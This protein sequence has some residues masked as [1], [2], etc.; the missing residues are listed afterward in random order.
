[1]T[2]FIITLLVISQILSFYLIFSRLKPKVIKPDGLVLKPIPKGVSYE[3]LDPNHDLIY[4]VLET[5]KLENW[6]LE[7]EMDFL[8]SGSHKLTFTSKDLTT[9]VRSRITDYSDEIR[10]SMFHISG[11]K[12]SVSLTSDEYLF[13][14]KTKVTNDIILFLW[15]YV[16][17]EYDDK[18]K[19]DKQRLN[20]SIEGIRNSLKTLK[21]SKRLNSIL[22]EET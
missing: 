15:D 5:I 19:K 16:I 14:E 10:L 20:S 1:M 17:E 6:N 9:T 2:I 22:D 13:P 21:R 12:G 11:K 7:I 8:G 3:D 4:E 18:N